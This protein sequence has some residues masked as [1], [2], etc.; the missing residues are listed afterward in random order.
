MLK[1]RDL[2]KS[3]G[4]TQQEI[5]DILGYNTRDSISKLELGK[6]TLD[7]EKLKVLI[8]ALQLNADEILALI[9]VKEIV[10]K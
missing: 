5:A 7:N 3:K 10:K 6:T 2:R 4:L 1:L 8:E 9:D